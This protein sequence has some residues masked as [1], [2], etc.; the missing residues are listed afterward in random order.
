[1]NSF[2]DKDIVL[3][4]TAAVTSQW[5]HYNNVQNPELRLSQYVNA[6]QWY[7]HNTPFRIVI[8]ENS[9][10]YQL[11]D[12]FDP[13]Y[14]N[15]L[16]L[17]CYVETNTTRNAGYNE[18]LI[19]RHLKE[20]SKF[21]ADSKLIFKVTG[22]LITRN[23]MSHVRQLRNKRGDFFAAHLFRNLLYID[24]RFFAFTTSKFD[25]ILAL[26][27]V[28][29]A[30]HWV[31]IKAGK[32]KNG[33][34]GLYVDFE[35]TIGAAIRNSLRNDKNSF[36]Y[37]AF[38]IIISGVEGFYGTKYDDSFWFR[39]KEHVKSF[40]WFLDWHFFV[41][42]TIGKRISELEKSLGIVTTP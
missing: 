10:Y 42:P 39:I 25:E 15:R 16:E 26:Q 20:E 6:I 13:K 34:N 24:S 19:L 22:R 2:K 5:S 28:C 14:H 11:L 29:C 7:L 21:I 17:I 18:M 4:L 27:D 1:M 12:H 35:S 9:G 38:P 8:G 30:I 23:I 3:L 33:E 31:D 36:Y 37:L 40:M 41:K 32:C